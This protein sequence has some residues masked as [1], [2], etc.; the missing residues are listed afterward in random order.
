MRF[1]VQAAAPQPCITRGNV[2]PGW[3]GVEHVSLDYIA[4]DMFFGVM[5][6]TAEGLKE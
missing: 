4:A 3:G 6:H 1:Y 2:K 5:N